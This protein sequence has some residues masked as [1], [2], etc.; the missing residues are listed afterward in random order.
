MAILED[1]YYYYSVWDWKTGTPLSVIDNHN[2]A[3]SRISDMKFINEED[4]ALLLTGS[5]M[6]PFLISDFVY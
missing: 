5:G 2:P 6:I 4:E 3:H 1:S